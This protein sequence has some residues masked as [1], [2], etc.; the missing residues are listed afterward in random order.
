MSVWVGWVVY[1]SVGSGAVR[2]RVG[3]EIRDK[4]GVCQVS[5]GRSRCGRGSHCGIVVL[6]RCRRGRYRGI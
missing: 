5:M 4:L 3:G 1:H 2:V 6:G